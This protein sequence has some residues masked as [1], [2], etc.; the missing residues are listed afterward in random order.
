[1]DKNIKKYKTIAVLGIIL[2]G[3]GSYV[4]CLS[5]HQFT[6]NIGTLVLCFGIIVSVIGFNKWRP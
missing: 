4:S 2:M 6:S 3:V 1:M 5:E